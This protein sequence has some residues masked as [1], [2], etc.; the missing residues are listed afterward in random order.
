[1]MTI[2]SGACKSGACKF[3]AIFESENETCVNNYEIN[4]PILLI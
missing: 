1:M 3:P 4:I 2:K